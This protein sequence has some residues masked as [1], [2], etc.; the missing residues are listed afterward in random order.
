MGVH[1]MGVLPNG[2]PLIGV[3]L[4]ACL[5]WRA[6]RRRVSHGMPL[7]SVH[8]IGVSLIGVSLIGVSSIGVPLKACIPCACISWACIH[9][10]AS[11]GRASIGVHLMACI[12]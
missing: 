7:I 4:M 6:S 3:S 12:S 9:R 8:S 10:R 11:H 5:S 1:L 2:V